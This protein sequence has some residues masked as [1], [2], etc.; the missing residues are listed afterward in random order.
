MKE[1]KF[2][3]IDEPW[4]IATDKF[5]KMRTLSLSET[6]AMSHELKALSGEMPAQDVAVLR[7]LLGVLY[8]VY[9]RTK[10]YSIARD[11]E[12]SS[13]VR[14]LWK[15]IWDAGKFDEEKIAA[16]FHTYHDRFWLIHP[17][18]PF[19][20]VA[21]DSNSL[22]I[23]NNGITIKP[24]VVDVVKFI[25]DIANL[26][27]L[28]CARSQHYGVDYPEA[29]RWLIHLNAFDVSPGGNPGKNAKSIKGYG[30]PWPADI[31]L[32]WI[33]GNTLF[34]TLMLNLVLV[35]ELDEEFWCESSAWW[36]IDAHCTHVDDLERT[37]KSFPK[38]IVELMSMQYRYVKLLTEHNIVTGIEL[39][40]GV[41]FTGGNP[42][43]EQMTPWKRD[44][45]NN[46]RPHRHEISKQMWRDFSAI[47]PYSN[48]MRPGVLQWVDSLMLESRHI[49]VNTVG[50]QYKNE[51]AVKDI[52]SDAL[53]LNA[54][55]LSKL[56]DGWV[57]RITRVLEITEKMAIQLGI[58][59]YDLAKAS[60]ENSKGNKSANAS[61]NRVIEEAYFRLD[62]PF[63]SW[64][65]DINPQTD[66]IEVLAL[67][68]IS[69]ARKIVLSLGEEIVS[70]AGVKAFVGREVGKDNKKVRC[71]APE[72]YSKFRRIVQSLK[73]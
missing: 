56:S 34:E 60:G 42:L 54:N 30:H 61:K 21:F 71:T 33:S 19:Y 68:W 15:D 53:M 40:S 35:P 1:K 28:F 67:S 70:Q 12:D 20:Q 36:E 22:P 5:G 50:V 26:E 51:S 52:Y 65:V 41:R 17:E 7:L 45:E 39:W 73:E 63:R 43:V 38:G 16:Y 64:L 48:D 27:N 58:L 59:A 44:K 69:T 29:A 57:I 31:G 62:M 47:I 46:I 4:I 66:D 72:A 6:I 13:V 49:R 37:N 23:N 11:D 24:T 10:E 25:G 18:L 8:A 55:L 14:R 3:L 9:T 2:N 32:V